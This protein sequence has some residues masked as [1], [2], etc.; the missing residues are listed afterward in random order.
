MVYS[1]NYPT[2]LVVED[3]PDLLAVIAGALRNGGFNVLA[4]LSGTEAES[5]CA[6]S[7]QQIALVVLD[8][9]LPG[10]NGLQL[11]HSLSSRYPALRFLFI[12]GDLNAASSIAAEGWTCMTKPFSFDE[13]VA[14][15]R[16]Q[17]R[18]L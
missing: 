4:A 8:F 3:E 16:A 5:Y 17:V 1:A 11:A 12:T 9:N 6:A 2:V 15:V 18:S 7:L 14:L 10:Q 13:L